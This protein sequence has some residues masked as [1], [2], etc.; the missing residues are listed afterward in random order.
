VWTPPHFW[1]LAIRRREEYARAGLPMLPVTHGIA[2]TKFQI[3]LYTLMLVAVSLL[4]FVT[5]MSGLIYLSGAVALGIG[6]VYHAIALYRSKG[7]EHAMQTFGYSIFYLSVLFAF[8][9]ADHYA[10]IVVRALAG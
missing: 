6:F 2:Y 8:L 7:D 9:L 5:R 4:P 3:L 1:A 10:Q